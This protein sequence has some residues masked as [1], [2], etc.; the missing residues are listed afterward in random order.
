MAKQMW[1]VHTYF[2]SICKLSC[3]CL[4]FGFLDVCL[5]DLPIQ[6]A[7][8][9]QS[10]TYGHRC[11]PLTADLQKRRK[12]FINT[13]RSSTTTVNIWGRKKREKRKKEEKRK[14]KRGQRSLT[15]IG[16]SLCVAA[17]AQSKHST[18]NLHMENIMLHRCGML[19]STDDSF[20]DKQNT[21][22]QQANQD[23]SVSL[24]SI[25]RF[26]HIM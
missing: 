1:K 17:A 18:E 5:S 15:S 4:L 23:A 6:I 19:P 26:E 12:K 21:E 25:S 7:W 14:R 16:N 10:Q 8:L 22:V 9:W 11:N 3:E 2:F 24:F 20:T 13:I